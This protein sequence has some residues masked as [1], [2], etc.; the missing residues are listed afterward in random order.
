MK[1][2]VW[3]AEARKYVGLREVKGPDHTPEILQWWRDIRLGGIKDDETPWCAAYV[4]AMLE[5]VGLVSTRSGWARSYLDWGKPINNPE[6]GC[7]VVFSRDGGGGHV[8]FVVGRDEKMRLLVLGGNQ[9]DQVNIKAFDHSRV[10]GFRWPHLV[11]PPVPSPLPV[12]TAAEL[13]LRED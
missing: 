5:N 12:L 4:G 1:D 3:L 8:G 13:S 6:Y 7:V 10:L 2:P 11:K 9:S